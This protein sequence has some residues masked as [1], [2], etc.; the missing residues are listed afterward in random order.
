MGL[1][2][3]IVND[4]N[5]YDV[6]IIGGGPACMSACI[7]LCR[8]GLKVAYIEK[9]VPGGRLVNIANI[10]NYP[11]FDH[12]SGPDLALKMY[13]Q[14][15]KLGAVLL[16]GEVIGIDRYKNYHVVYTK[17]GTTR[18]CHA[19]IIA[20]GNS[21]NKLDA[22]DA[23]KYENKGLSYCAICDGSLAKNKNVVVVGGGDSAISNA[24]Y[25]SRIAANVSIIHRRDELRAR[26]EFVDQAK[27]IKNIN[28]ILNSIV[29]DVIGDN[30]HVTG[31]K[32]KNVKTKKISDLKCEFIFVY[33][34]STSSTG[35]IKNKSLLNDHGLIK[36][37]IHM[38]TSE[39]GL[40][41]IGDVAENNSNQITQCV[42]EGTIAA[43]NII[44]YL[45]KNNE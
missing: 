25:L 19:L 6:L 20:T 24:I 5:L 17:D 11:G 39:L 15:D 33:I 41:A 9:N 38:Q 34:G 14:I 22:I 10:E 4:D 16:Y 23:E 18:Y 7:Y 26:K 13:E 37:D 35:F 28:F 32:I 3:R 36:H 43:L 27:K 40:Y 29:T 12:I 31:L 8:A 45:N 1:E 2:T 42:S 30:K 21:N 44:N